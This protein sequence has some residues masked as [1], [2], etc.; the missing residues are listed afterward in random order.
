M[1]AVLCASALS[2]IALSTAAQAADVAMPTA[3]DW[4]GF[5]VGLNAGAAMNDTD[6]SNE[7]ISNN[8]R[9]EQLQFDVTND[10]T[11]FTGGGMIGYNHQID[12]VV[13]GVEA[14]F[15]YLGF[16]KDQNNTVVYT[17][18][19]FPVEVRTIND[20]SFEADWFGTIRARLGYS[21]DNILVYGTGGAAYGHMSMSQDYSACFRQCLDLLEADEDTVNWGW[22]AGGGVEIGFDRFSVG[23]E[24]LYVDLGSA[25]W[26]TNSVDVINSSGDA[27]GDVDW[28][29]S[30]V[31]ATAKM[32]F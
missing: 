9:V 13:L 3:Y 2:I 22:T 27:N 15:N 18:Q 14:D 1:K 26:E 10:E 30:V 7:F 6:V 29:F 11:A 28:Q 12:R 8:R 20:L 23:A 25:D 16:N 17:P 4:S 5:Y 31:R 32:R 21:F 24:Y 19:E